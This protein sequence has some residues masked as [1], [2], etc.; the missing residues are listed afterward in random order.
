[1]VTKERIGLNMEYKYSD[2]S[3]YKGEHGV[4]CYCYGLIKGDICYGNVTLQ[5][6][7]WNPEGYYEWVYC[8]QAHCDGRGYDILTKGKRMRN[9]T[10]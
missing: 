3:Y 6:E 8:C 9:E 1:M 4:D 10:M 7:L 5:K 2:E